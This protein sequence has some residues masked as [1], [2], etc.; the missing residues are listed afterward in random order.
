[1]ASVNPQSLQIFSCHTRKLYCRLV[2]N[3]HHLHMRG[4]QMIFFLIIDADHIRLPLEELN[5][6]YSQNIHLTC[7]REVN[8]CIQFLDVMVTKEP[9][10][11]ISTAWY[12][13]D[14]AS[15]RH[16][17]DITSVTL[18]E[19]KVGRRNWYHSLGSLVSWN[20]WVFL[21]EFFRNVYVWV[22]VCMNAGAN[23]LG[24]LNLSYLRH[25][26]GLHGNPDGPGC[27]YKNPSMALLKSWTS[28]RFSESK[29]YWGKARFR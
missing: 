19:K 25:I 18:R 1:M 17:L 16:M 28:L 27:R 11:A 24:R 21:E 20:I 22:P 2:L 6:R 3:S 5:N 23:A 15:G 12:Q 9:D 7:G 13:K 10:S 4:M 8:S 26:H 14:I 29:Q